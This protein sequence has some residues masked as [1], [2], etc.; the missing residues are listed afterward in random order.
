MPLNPFKTDAAPAE[1]AGH[2]LKCLMCQHESFHQRKSHLDTALA[3]SMSPDWVDR[4]AY[5][6]VCNECGFIHWFLA[7]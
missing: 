1:V 6:L 5:C 7:K 2:K 3:N 4:Q